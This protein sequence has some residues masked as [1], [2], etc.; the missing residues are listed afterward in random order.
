MSALS[1]SHP[2]V[3]LALLAV[4]G[5]AL[6]AGR[7][8]SSGSPKR[9][10]LWLALQALAPALLVLALA[11]PQLHSGSGR[12]TVLAVDQS[13][14]V[15]P[16][17]QALERRWT[18]Q[19]Q[20]D[21]CVSP[22]RVVRFA[23]T[24][25]ATPPPLA[26]APGLDAGATDLQSAIGA[27]IGLAPVGGR[28]AVL[29]D[30]GQ[31][32]GDLLATAPLARRRSVE[33]DWVRLGEPTRPDAAVTAISTP[34]VV[35]LGDTVPLTLTVH[36]TV[37]ARAVLSVRTGS[38]G[39][40]ASQQ[41]ALRSGDNPLLL[42]YT[43]AAKGWQS[44]QA[45]IS[46]AEDAVS[47]NNSLA[48]VT[49]VVSSPRV[50][51]VG[52]AHSAVPGLLVHEGLSVTQVEPASLPT[53]ASSYSGQDAVVLND[54]SASQLGAGQIAAL[55]EAV[56]DEGLGLVVLGGQHS[57]SLGGYARSPLQQ[58]LPVSSLVPGNLQRRN[59]AISL[60]LDHS[61][62]MSELAGGV[63]KIAMARAAATQSA[64]FL[65]AH[66]EALGIVDFD[67]KPHTLVPLQLLTSAADEHRVDRT[68]A[69]L[70]ADGGT[71]IYLGLKAGLEQLLASKA[72]QRHIILMTDGIS[73]PA[74]Y[75]PLLAQ[76]RR[77]HITV[78]TVALGADADRTLLAEIA[79]GTGGRAYVTDNAK[80]LPRI[81]VKET[82]LSAKPVRVTGHLSVQLASDSAVVRSLIGKRLPALGGNVVTELKSGA[83]ADLLASNTGSQLDPALAEWQVGTGRVVAWTPGLDSAW[84]GEWL[85]E[86]ALW[87]DAVRW[88]ERGVAP[89]PLTPEPLGP[90]GSL[91]I[92]LAGAGGQALGVR[93]VEGTLTDDRGLVRPISFLPVG[94]SLYDANVASFPAG[95]YRFAL[96]TVGPL[97]QS[98]TGE[99]AIGYPAE[100]SPVSVHVSPMAQLV[101]QAGGR[102]V[103]ADD[104][105]ALGSSEH[106]EWRLLALLALVVFLIG[107]AG[108]MLSSSGAARTSTR[109]D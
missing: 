32:Q 91:Q 21:D 100:Y 22:C 102:I 4:A 39:H 3:L 94:P 70:Q 45:T 38:A 1:F 40:T 63:E 96:H 9:E 84:A 36:S 101:A 47:A 23:S 82:Q 10:W 42:L 78:A 93:A 81:F 90:S 106:S 86:T 37:A 35:H 89:A 29:S 58:V 41:V 53:R 26:G 61:G 80:E 103:P 49:D 72:E 55:N 43:A 77:A 71:N 98:A 83:Q 48:A 12:P 66:Q 6:L 5:G 14:S 87:N 69:G 18:A 33:V 20:K 97:S 92:D 75:A 13:A 46:L 95:V 24:P 99:L 27:A 62:S 30:G 73:Q 88:T 52:G 15:D 74:N 2:L 64:A 76:L 56:R 25:A 19:V 28:V 109:A 79:A 67:I 50:L 8:L 54:V 7:R 108:R 31:T 60:V 16:S 104:L 85:A 57:F 44:F 11:G 68:V 107:V 105:G 34:P 17:M 51:S 65:R 59:L